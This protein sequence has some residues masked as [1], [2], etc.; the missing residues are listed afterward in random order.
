MKK[1]ATTILILAVAIVMPMPAI[2]L[3]QCT[4]CD[5]PATTNNGEF[6]IELT[7]FARV[8]G[9]AIYEYTI[10]KTDKD[11]G[12]W[13]LGVNLGC[14]GSDPETDEPYTLGDLIWSY[15][16]EN[17]DGD[18]LGG[19]VEVKDISPDPTTGITGIKIEGFGEESPLIFTLVLDES[20]LADGWILGVGC[21]PAAT[22]AKNVDYACVMGPVCVEDTECELRIETAFGGDTGVNVGS[23]GAWFYYFDTSGDATQK[24]YAGQTKEVG[25]VTYTNDDGKITIVLTD[26]WE[27]QDVDEPVKIQGYNDAPDSRPAAGHFEH[28]GDELEVPVDPFDFFVIHLDVQICE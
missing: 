24:I 16:V 19:T 14:L 9:M 12:H 28:K 5:Y 22:K 10:T 23:P 7:D 18:D 1:T 2:V 26:G 15:T 11:L 6:T 8:G 20:K 25:T 13:V 4:E 3:A 21:V 17:E 27:L